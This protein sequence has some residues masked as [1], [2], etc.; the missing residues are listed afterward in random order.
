MNDQKAFPYLERTERGDASSLVKNAYKEV[1]QGELFSPKTPKIFAQYLPK[2]GK[3]LDLGSSSGRIFPILESI[4]ITDT[5][6]AD[7]DEYLTV[8]RPAGSFSTF[9]FSTDRFPYED[10]SFDGITSIEVVE[11]LENPYHFLRECARIL[12]PGG[13]LIVST[14]NPD[15][16]YNKISFLV[17]GKFYRFLDGNDHIMLF[18]HYVLSK[19]ALK[20]FDLVAR[21]YMFGEM[22]YRIFSKFTYPENKTFGRTAFYILKKK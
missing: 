3:V 16:F 17:R 11:H 20:Y 4:G 6:G 22:P 13:V 15:H 12:K 7:I 8:A 21:E 5:H 14:P 10:A 9:D 19:G 1:D 2:G 18:A